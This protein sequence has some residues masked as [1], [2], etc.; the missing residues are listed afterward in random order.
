MLVEQPLNPMKQKMLN[1]LRASMLVSALELI[2]R[3]V[4]KMKGSLFA[5]GRS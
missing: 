5:D 3:L 4:W 2:D 1:D